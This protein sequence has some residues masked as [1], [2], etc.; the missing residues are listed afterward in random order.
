MNNETN[1]IENRQIMKKEYVMLFAIAATA[2]MM[3]FSLTPAFAAADLAGLLDQMIGIVEKIFVAV[4]IILLV[5]SIGQLI[6]AFKNE[7]ADSKSR[8]STM[9]VVAAVLIVFPS[10]IE[11]LDLTSYLK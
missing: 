4:G 7:D 6:Q 1:V 10:L 9:L 2:F 5:Y 11:Q 3:L 8:A